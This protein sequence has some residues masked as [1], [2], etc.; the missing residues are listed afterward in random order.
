VSLENIQRF[1]VPSDLVRTTE[2]KLRR[3]GRDGYELFVL[4][5]GIAAGDTIEIDTAHV[6]EQTSYKTKKGLLVR[7]EGDALHKLNVWLYEHE[8]VLAAQVHA[9]PTDAFHSSTDDAFPIVTELG[10]LSLVAPDFARGGILCEGAA[11]YRLAV[12][13]WL[14]IPPAELSDVIQVVP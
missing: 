7:V 13:G 11:G 4:W 1:R 12:E 8:Q 2:R 3:A 9:H 5:S 6:P 14:E 10:G